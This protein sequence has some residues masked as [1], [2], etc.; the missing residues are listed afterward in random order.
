MV[1]SL[2]LTTHSSVLRKSQ[3]RLGRVA[4]AAVKEDE[5]RRSLQRFGE[6]CGLAA[7]EQ[8]TGGRTRMSF[9]LDSP[10]IEQLI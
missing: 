3:H 6:G 2:K 9:S 7:K 8:R 10:F 4:A 1:G 5:E